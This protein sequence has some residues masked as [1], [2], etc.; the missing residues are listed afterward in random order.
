[1][2]DVLCHYEDPQ[3]GRVT[4]DPRSSVRTL[5]IARRSSVPAIWLP[6][7]GAEQDRSPRQERGRLGTAVL[8]LLRG[9]SFCLRLVRVF[10]F[11]F[12]RGWL[13][14][15]FCPSYPDRK[16][17]F[18]R[19]WTLGCQ[20]VIAS[21]TNENFQQRGTRQSRFARWLR[22]M[23]LVAGTWGAL[24]SWRRALPHSLLVALSS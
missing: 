19:C 4:C 7:V 5:C 11:V 21:S 13:T 1:M 22:S 18:L 17:T 10:V 12:G 8:G 3:D 20:E 14:L 23:Y 6:G 24:T 15:D 9:S 2:Q 16:I